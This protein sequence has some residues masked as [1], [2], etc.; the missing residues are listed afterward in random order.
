MMGTHEVAKKDCAD[1][2]CDGSGAGTGVGLGGVQAVAA[3]ETCFAVDAG[4]SARRAGIPEELRTLPLSHD[5][6]G[7]ARA[8]IAGDHEGESDALGR[9]ADR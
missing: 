7:V 4:G 5:D 1:H 8:G 9:A 3:V 2:W 6:G